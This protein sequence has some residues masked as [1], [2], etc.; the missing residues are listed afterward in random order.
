MMTPFTANIPTVNSCA[1]SRIMVRFA[2]FLSCDIP[3]ETGRP[4]TQ[5]DDGIV[6]EDIIRGDLSLSPWN[7]SCFDSRYYDFSTNPGGAYYTFGDVDVVIRDSLFD[8][9]VGEWHDDFF[10]LPLCLD[11]FASCPILCVC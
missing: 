8:G 3:T 11:C 9:N 4:P 1:T 6:V 10:L 5:T 2:N 7:Q